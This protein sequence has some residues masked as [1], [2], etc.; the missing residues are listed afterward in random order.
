M[1]LIH[2]INIAFGVLLV[3]VFVVI[4][5]IIHYVLMDHF[6][7]TQ[8]QDMVALGSAMSAQI[9]KQAQLTAVPL[10]TVKIE[11]P[12]PA[13]SFTKVSTITPMA[14]INFILSDQN[15]KIV[16]RGP[17]HLDSTIVST[18]TTASAIN[19]SL[20]S[21]AELKKIKEGKDSRYLVA[22]NTIP[23][24]DLT[25]IT[26]MSQIKEIEQKLFVRLIVTMCIGGA[27]MFLLSLFIT[28]RLIKPLM[29]LRE[30][31]SKVKSRQFAD[32]QLIRAG[33]EIG[34]VAET[35]YDLAG[36]L[37]R[38]NQ[39]QKQFFQNASHELKTPLMSIAGYAEGIRD[40]VFE[41]D[42][43]KK[44]LNIIINES[45]RLK[46][47]VTEM[48][49]L[50]KLD[51]EE[52]IFQ[53][54][55]VCVQDLVQ[56][57]VERI[58]PLILRK[59]ILLKTIYSNEDDRFVI[60]ADRDKLLQALLN[61]VSNAVRHAKQEITIQVTLDKQKV[62][63]TVQDDGAGIPEALLPQLFHR[64]VKGKNGDTG[65]GLAISR[66]IVERCKGIIQA[67]NRPEGGATIS[68]S[69]PSGKMIS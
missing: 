56:E 51:S 41:G 11:A 28:R 33:G 32:V 57:T 48:T 15:G 3:G 65:L 19:A 29:K 18:S 44:G 67:G 8:K 26:P 49:L 59:G 12:S 53:F 60:A 46:N 31:L 16:E 42:A 43:T 45:G 54:S 66:A 1:K 34:A 30:E 22:V 36:E 9:T 27:I 58:N 17:S 14:K 63:I 39:V 5:I 61:V 52:D 35:V 10:K 40:G 4:A 55:D 25:L 68:L 37:E 50:A 23:D 38:Y 47:I 2:Q 6:I 69:F 24:G 7:G 20:I 62:Q 64:F 13:K 21:E